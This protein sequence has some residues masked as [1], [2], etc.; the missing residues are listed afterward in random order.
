M[1]RIPA[2]LSLAFVLALVACATPEPTSA[3]TA[4]EEPPTATQEPPT[5]TPEPSATATSET[6]S[7]EEPTGE[8]I[9]S[10]VDITYRLQVITVPVGTTVT[11]VYDAGL[12]H[13]VTS[14]TGLFN[15][16]TMGEGDRFSFAFTEEGIFPY[17]C[18]FHGSPG[19]N[20]MSG[21]VEVTEG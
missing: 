9:V 1:K 17:F 19:G 2:Y 16:A 13:T 14:D 21:V 4:T 8:D 11:W 12:P 7:E 10:V 3:P 18:R 5:V 20:G 6:I 15:S